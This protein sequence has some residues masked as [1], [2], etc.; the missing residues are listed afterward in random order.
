MRF[1]KV[2]LALNKVACTIDKCGLYT[3]IPTKDKLQ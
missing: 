1:Y 2:G 3:G